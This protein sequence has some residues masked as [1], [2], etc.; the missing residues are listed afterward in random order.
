MKKQSSPQRK[1]AINEMPKSNFDTRRLMRAVL[2][3][4][5]VAYRSGIEAR[6]A[7]RRV[8]A[9]KVEAWVA[10][11]DRDWPFAFEN[12]CSVLGVDPGSIRSGLKQL[13]RRALEA[14]ENRSQS[15]RMRR[16]PLGA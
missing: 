12:V 9:C 5:L 8:E 2:A 4:A 7:S 15:R 14:C 16:S 6:T 11:T 10:S 1:N 3:E 13:R